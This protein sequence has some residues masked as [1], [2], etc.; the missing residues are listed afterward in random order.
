MNN[1]DLVI[2][3]NTLIDASFK[4]TLSE[5]RLL[6]IVFAE[7]SDNSDGSDGF[8][9]NDFKV[10]A[11]QYS[12]I[13]EVDKSTAYEALQDASDAYFIVISNTKE[14]YIKNLILWKW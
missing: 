4:L 8:Y 10:T 9:N 13:Y 7:I 11:E 3:S 2:K 12:Q 14:R 6:N 1:N 5:F